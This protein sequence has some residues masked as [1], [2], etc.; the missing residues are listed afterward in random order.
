[1]AMRVRRVLTYARLIRHAR[2]SQRSQSYHILVEFARLLDLAWEVSVVSAPICSRCGHRFRTST[3]ASHSSQRHLRIKFSD[4]NM[5]LNFCR[6]ISKASVHSSWSL[7][8]G[9]AVPGPQQTTSSVSCHT[10]SKRR[11]QIHQPL[12]R[13]SMRPSCGYVPPSRSFQHTPSPSSRILRRWQLF[14]T[15]RVCACTPLHLETVFYRHM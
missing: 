12:N 15:S 9:T 8:S 6:P 10:K 11:Y 13:H 1:M 3:A 2:H 14:L 5:R 7:L 4:H